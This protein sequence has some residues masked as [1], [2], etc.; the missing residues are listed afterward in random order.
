[1]LVW[2]IFSIPETYI[3][4]NTFFDISVKSAISPATVSCS[5]PI[6]GYN[7]CVTHKP[8]RRLLITYLALALL[9]VALVLVLRP[10][11]TVYLDLLRQGDEH[12]ARVERTAAVAVYREAARV[13]PGDPTPYLR[14]AQLYLDWGRTDDALAA[15]SEAERLGADGAEDA[16]LE[17]LW[18]AVHVARAD[19]PAVVEHAERLLALAPAT[20]DDAD[21]R[22]TIA[23]A[24]VELQ[25]W[26]L[27]RAEYE[28][29]LRA[30]PADALA[31]ER[32]GA[33]TLGEGPAAIQHLFAA[34]T[35]LAERLLVALRQA[36]TADDPA[37]GSALL[38]QVLFEEQ[39]WALAAR[40]FEWAL[41]HNP[42]YAD[43]HAYLGYALDQMGRSGEA[44][45]HLLRAV[46]LAP[47]SAV[48]HTFL[49]MH[50][51]RLGDVS[52]ARAE[53]E[54]AYDLDPTNPATCVEVGHT[55]AAER[56][57]V[58]AEIWLREAVS[59]RPDDP[60][61]WEILARFYLD[62]GITAGGRSVEA[63]A[64]LVELAPDDAGAHDL[65]GW[66][67]FQVGDYD[68]AQE[69]LLRATALNPTLAAAHYHLGRLW[70]AQGAR[71][72]AQGV[73]E[74]A[75]GVREKAQGAREKAQGAHEKAQ[76]AFI[77]ALDLDT[78]GELIPLVERAMGE[79]SR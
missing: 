21:A 37:Y 33:L 72:K 48:S 26:D 9:T 77:R 73:R 7:G 25:E 69:S 46:A 13:R 29:L 71:E 10:T 65:R 67:A 38:G 16:A 56:R 14:L 30:D 40:Q 57:Y 12:A 78:S 50:Y 54:A 63:A 20:A 74:K 68:T 47:V 1:M 59:L 66:A 5:S 36:G 61:L 32:L 2:G 51:D 62:Q 34:R 24:Y 49:G 22:H 4:V 44:R 27:A 75:Q 79:G 39:E 45:P 23:R 35:D 18:V 31:H 11:S 28:A 42:D 76:G 55:W 17:R 19:W 58:A 41:S 60:A 3:K 6:Y 53:Y 43:A 64:R 15:L 70:A 52:A 8:D